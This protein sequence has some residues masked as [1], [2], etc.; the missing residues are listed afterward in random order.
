MEDAQ[1]QMT[2]AAEVF[3]SPEFKQRIDEMTRKAEKHAWTFEEPS[4]PEEKAPTN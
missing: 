4:L 1:R 3:E 2:K